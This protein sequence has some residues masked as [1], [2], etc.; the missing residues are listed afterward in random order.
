MV[1]LVLGA[2]TTEIVPSLVA[3]TDP[4]TLGIFQAQVTKTA[5]IVATTAS[6]PAPALQTQTASLPR[7]S[8][9]GQP[10]SLDSEEDT[11]QFVITS[12][13]SAPD[14][15]ASVPLSDP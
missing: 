2:R 13:S 1:L 11:S 10:D 9:E 3:L 8:T 14:T 15:T 12:R 6:A 5:P 7:L 4:P